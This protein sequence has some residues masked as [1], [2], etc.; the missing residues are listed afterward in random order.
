[1]GSVRSHSL[2]L[3][4]WSR[5]LGWLCDQDA[6]IA[7]ETLMQPTE[8]LRDDRQRRLD[9]YLFGFVNVE[10]GELDVLRERPIV[11]LLGHTASAQI[12]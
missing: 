3:P 12:G 7:G 9:L 10:Q 2:D 1:M 8:S 4:T 5:G 6:D 11:V